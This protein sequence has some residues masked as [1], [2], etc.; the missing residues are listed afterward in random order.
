MRS[1]NSQEFSEP[2]V[3]LRLSNNAF[4]ST[5]LISLLDKA[6]DVLLLVVAAWTQN[7]IE[8]LFFGTPT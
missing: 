6:V 5:K 2:L 3:I 1:G 4:L 8:S 7:L